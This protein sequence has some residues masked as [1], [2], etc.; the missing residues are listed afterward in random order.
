MYFQF[1]CNVCGYEWNIPAN[2]NLKYK[3]CPTCGS[4]NVNDDKENEEKR[5]ANND[6]ND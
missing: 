3:Q 5:D 4:L 6:K 2:S 1:D